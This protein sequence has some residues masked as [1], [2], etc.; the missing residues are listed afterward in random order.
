MTP[1]GLKFNPIS[2]GKFVLAEYRPFEIT[3]S[4][5]DKSYLIETLIFI[6]SFKYF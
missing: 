6:C 2:E 4:K 1:L 5:V 3:I